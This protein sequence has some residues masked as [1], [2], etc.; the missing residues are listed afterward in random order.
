MLWEH[1]LTDYYPCPLE[2][3]LESPTNVVDLSTV[4][5]F[6]NPIEE[7]NWNHSGASHVAPLQDATFL[8]A[9]EQGQGY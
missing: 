5:L 1:Y 2:M 4:M 7:N 6:W 9:V 8:T 3:G